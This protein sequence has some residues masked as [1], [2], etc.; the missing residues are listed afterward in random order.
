VD[1]CGIAEEKRPPLTEVRRDAVMDVVGRD[2]AA[3][4]Q[5]ATLLL[6]N[7]GVPFLYYG[8]EIGLRGRKPDER[9]RTPMPWTEAAP[10]YG[11]TT[12]SPWEPL[13]EGVEVSN[14][15]AQRSDDASLLSHYRSLIA[16]RAGHP[17]LGPGGTLV[18]LEA[19]VKGVYAVLR[20]DPT[21]GEVLAVISNLTGET[22]GDIAVSLAEGPLCGSPTAA[23]VHGTASRLSAPRI[24]PT[25]GIDPWIVGRLGPHEDR[26]IALAP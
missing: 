4:R 19:S 9:I 18:P 2:A 11:F 6:T 14:V 5:A 22:V 25:G 15:A 1:V 3:A 10:G 17:A 26:I 12:G 24:I 20:H 16:L 13:A 23:V 8:E 7:P 21:S